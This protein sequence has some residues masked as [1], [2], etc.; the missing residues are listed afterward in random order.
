MT[1]ATG[2]VSVTSVFSTTSMTSSSSLVVGV[3]HR[4]EIYQA[5]Q[6]AP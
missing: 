5:M 3:G 4:R 6:Q 2:C 1:T